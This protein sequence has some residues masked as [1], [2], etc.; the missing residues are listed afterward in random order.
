[1]AKVSLKST[2]QYFVDNVGIYSVD[3]E[4]VYQIGQS[5]KTERF[6]SVSWEGLTRKLLAKHSCLYHFAGCL[7]ARYPWKLFNLR[8][9]WVFTLSFSHTQPL[10]LNPIINTG[11][12]KCLSNRTIWKNIMFCECLVGRSYP[13]ATRETQ[14][15]PSVLTLCIPVMCKTHA[16]FYGMLSCEIPMKT[17]Q[18]SIAWVFTH[19]LS[20]TTLTI[21]SHNK[22][23]VQKIE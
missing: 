23:K 9:A 7:V 3:T 2:T 16:L 4:S 10:Q 11:Y 20:H 1:M 17:F 8:F 12:K 19:T 21:E 18:F 15:S 6:A 22:Y 5:G 14:L 13:R